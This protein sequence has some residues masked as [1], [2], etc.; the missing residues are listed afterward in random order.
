[1]N[2]FFT[3]INQGLFGKYFSL[4]FLKKRHISGIIVKSHIRI[5]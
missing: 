5:G 4:D 1:M 2:D 3:L